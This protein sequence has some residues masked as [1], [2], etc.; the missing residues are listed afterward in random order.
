MR[1]AFIRSFGGPDVFEIRD[2]DKPKPMMS[3]VLIRAKAIGVNPVET[4][5]RSGRYKIVEPPAI[6]GWD[7]SGVIEE[8]VAGVNRFEVG[9]EVF[10]MPFFPRPARTYAEH[11][12]APSRQIALKP[13][14]LG[15]A[16]AA[17][18]ALAGLTAWQALHDVAKVRSGQR[19]LVH[20]AAGGVGHLAVQIAK[21]LGAEVIAT[22][23]G[24]NRDF[25]T[26]LGADQFI[27][28]EK[29]DFAEVAKDVDVVL[30]SVGKDYGTRSIGVLKPSGALITLVERENAELKSKVEKAG[31]R[32]I[33][34]TVEPDGHGLE[35]LAALT[36][37]GKLR[38][39]VSHEIPL[40][41]AGRAHELLEKGGTRGKI[42]LIP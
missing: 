38:V 16:E 7:I 18:L 35:R 37:E 40:A 19:V 11:A 12:I 26:S 24:K 30:E 32:F 13:A 8:L 23:S 39:H 31:R 29:S 20:A 14:S 34:L 2:V 5:V 27:D 21:A 6:L 10:G 28:Y 4:K 3:E 1:A 22:A 33:P 41:E 42:V 9:D 36:T 17:A 25:V 15:H